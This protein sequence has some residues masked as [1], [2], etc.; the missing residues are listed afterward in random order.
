MFMAIGANGVG[1]GAG[2]PIVPAIDPV[3]SS[4]EIFT[5][6][7]NRPEY[8][9]KIPAQTLEQL[10][11]IDGHSSSPSLSADGKYVAFL[12]QRSTGGRARFNLAMATHDGRV[13]RYVESVGAG[14][15]RPAFVADR[16]LANELLDDRYEVKEF[17]LADG[18]PKILIRLNH[19]ASTLNGL[20]RIKITFDN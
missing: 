9:I 20:D 6:E 7:I 19:S 12:N 4:S 16:V 8:R 3:A 13:L 18:E 14:F 10:F 17:D 5:L 2:T 11:V 15:S 1:T